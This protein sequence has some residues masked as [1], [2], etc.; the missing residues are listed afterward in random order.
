MRRVEFCGDPMMPFSPT[1]YFGYDVFSNG[2]VNSPISRRRSRMEPKV[3]VGRG[4]G[5][6]MEDDMYFVFIDCVYTNYIFVY[7]L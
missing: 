1:K 6:M 3:F 7:D 4:K 2:S 5:G